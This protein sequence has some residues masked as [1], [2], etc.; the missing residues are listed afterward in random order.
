MGG[1]ALGVIPLFLNR[2]RIWA[3]LPQRG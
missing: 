2:K 1:I 3:P